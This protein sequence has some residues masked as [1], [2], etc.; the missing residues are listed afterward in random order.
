VFQALS[1]RFP[2]IKM[3]Q[4]LFPLIKT[5]DQV[6]EIFSQIN[7]EIQNIILCTIIN[8]DLLEYII[9]RSKRDNIQCNDILDNI[10]NDIANFLKTEISYFGRKFEIDKDNFYYER[11]RAI[12]FTI[13]HDDGQMISTIDEADIIILGISRTSK[14]PT[15]IYL[16]NRGLKVANIPIIK[17]F[18][19]S[20]LR[21]L[22]K[23]KFIIALYNDPERLIQVRK[24]RMR[25]ISPKIK[26]SYIDYDEI[27]S[28]SEWAISLYKKMNI[29]IID[30]TNKA[31]EES[32]AL[33]LQSY[34]R[35]L[36][37]L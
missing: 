9:Y 30:V 6:D 32:A 14:T 27:S 28:E 29:Q 24:E 11:M 31:V 7:N 8:Q 10:T 22:K 33:I 5:E 35:Y 20:Y 1:A 19:F 34:N 16:A 21:D 12:N 4:F 17:N 18:D 13:A 2:N 37:I 23:K 15:S 3:N 36:N 25:N 26:I